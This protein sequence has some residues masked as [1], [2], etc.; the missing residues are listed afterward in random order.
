MRAKCVKFR[1]GMMRWD[2]IWCADKEK[3]HQKHEAIMAIMMIVT[4]AHVWNLWS[5]VDM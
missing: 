2:L 3:S 5:D 1:Y 4:H